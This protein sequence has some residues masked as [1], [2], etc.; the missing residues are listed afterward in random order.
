MGSRAPYWVVL[1]AILIWLPLFFHTV[2]GFKLAFEGR[3]NLLLY[4]HFE[5]W[6]YSLQRL[7]GVLS[8]GFIVYHFWHFRLPLLTGKIGEHDLFPELCASLSST[9]R[10]VPAVALAYLVGIAAATFHLANGLSGFCFSWGITQSRRATRVAGGLF[11]IFGAA[12]F[13][14]GANT[15]IYFATGSGL[16]LL[17][18]GQSGQAV[19]VS[20][21]DIG[22]ASASGT[23]PADEHLAQETAR[24]SGAKGDGN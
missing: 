24:G 7:T 8:A 15:L 9:V 19:A 5:N 2:Y 6:M 1:E 12:L 18:P 4:P 11:G 16:V 13:A 21:R 3:S 17:I 10:G 23:A 14:L 22:P 20:C